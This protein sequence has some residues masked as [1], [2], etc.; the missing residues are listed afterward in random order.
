MVMGALVAVM[1]II[2]GCGPFKGSSTYDTCVLNSDCTKVRDSCQ[3]VTSQI[4]GNVDRFCTQSCSVGADCPI[5]RNG[6]SGVCMC[7]N[8]CYS[9]CTTSSDCPIGWSCQTMNCR[10]GL[11]VC[12]PN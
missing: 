3:P 9:A 5:S 7:D 10:P 12:L 1:A 4:S 11:T 8:Q 6:A 2:S